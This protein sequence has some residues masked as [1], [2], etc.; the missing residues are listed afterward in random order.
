M[1]KN[2][3]YYLSADNKTQIHAV[4]WKPEKEIIGVIQIA[5]GVTEHILRYEQFAKF[6]TQKGFVV[7]GNDH[8][9]HGTSIA[10]N[11]KP[12][13]FGPKNSWNFV[14][15]DI[16]TCRKMT[17]EKYSDIP[18]VLLGF[19][20]GSFLVRTYLIDY[21]KE[22]IDA[23]IIMGTGYIPNF[24]I[25][26]AKMIANNEAKKVGEENTSPVI[27]SLTFETY[28]KLFK[29]NR[30]ECDWL[31]SN[32]KAIDEYLADP[33][34]GKNYSAGLFIE[35]LSG[36][37]YTSNLKNIKKMN[38]KIPIF[39]LSG[40][41]DPVGEFGKGVIKTFDILRKAGIENVDIKLYKDLRH[42]ILHE[43]NRNN[44]YADI[45]NWLE[46]NIDF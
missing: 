1:V 11:S 8:L 23:S 22:P 35:L 27:K 14:V 9:G 19:S 10:K 24:K 7:V 46:K 37:Q 12:M 42:D 4:E 44:I 30:T 31:C 29:P 6:F 18:Y 5:H 32:E 20:L 17:K 16:E 21:A 33:L 15:Q 25:A 13:Y 34:R 38:K 3:F 28:N 41:K 45:Y 39:L 43:E 2:E 26:I 40:D 36:M